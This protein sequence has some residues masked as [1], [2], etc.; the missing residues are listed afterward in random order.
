MGRTDAGSRTF[1]GPIE[2]TRWPRCI[3]IERKNCN[4]A[5]L[6]NPPLSFVTGF[7]KTLKHVL[8]TSAIAALAHPYGRQRSMVQPGSSVWARPC[9]ITSTIC[10]GVYLRLNQA[11]VPM[12]DF[13]HTKHHSVG[14]Q[15]TWQSFLR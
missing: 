14:R 11:C 6:C 2:S 8:M 13:E 7:P 3:A 15:R 5:F 9:P 10:Q 1:G 4:L 12:V